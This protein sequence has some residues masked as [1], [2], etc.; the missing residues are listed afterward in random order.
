MD[1]PGL[2]DMEMPTDPVGEDRLSH[3]RQAGQLALVPV[4]RKPSASSPQHRPGRGCRSEGTS[5]PLVAA[6]DRR[7]LAVGEVTMAMIDGVAAAVG[8][9]EQRVVPLGVEQ[10]RQRVRRDDGCRNRPSRRRADRYRGR[11]TGRRRNPRHSRGVRA[12]RLAR[13]Q[14]CPSCPRHKCATVRVSSDIRGNGGNSSPDNRSGSP[15][16]RRRRAAWRRPCRASPRST[17][18]G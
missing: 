7:E 13:D 12:Q 15:R 2:I 8:G 9:D 18:A 4:V 14:A 11:S 5:E 16:A 1:A 6:I 17:G 3:R 10:R